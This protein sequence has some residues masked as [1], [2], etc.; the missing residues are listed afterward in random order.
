MGGQ[1]QRPAGTSAAGLDNQQETCWRRGLQFLHP[2]PLRTPEGHAESQGPSLV[3]QDT[4]IGNPGPF[5][6]G[7]QAPPIHWVTDS[8]QGEFNGIPSLMFASCYLI[9]LVVRFRF[10]ADFC[11]D[12]PYI[13]FFFLVFEH[14]TTV[15]S[16]LP[17]SC[18][19]TS[20]VPD[21]FIDEPVFNVMVKC[22][23]YLF[24]PR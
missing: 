9:E 12:D 2:R 15:G 8:Q 10:S 16:K 5:Q 7:G 19:I 22:V 20:T 24:L 3:T 14:L 13:P 23:I 21:F 18:I 1:I 17:R 6:A 4:P 11:L